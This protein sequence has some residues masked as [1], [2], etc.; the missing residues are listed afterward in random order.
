MTPATPSLTV[1]TD[2]RLIRARWHSTR[3]IVARVTA[4]TSTSGR[5]RVSA[6]FVLPIR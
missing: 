1:T 6:V 2:R 4:P 5:G 3:Y